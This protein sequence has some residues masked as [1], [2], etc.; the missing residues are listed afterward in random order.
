[1][2]GVGDAYPS[3][4]NDDPLDDARDDSLGVSN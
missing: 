3:G 1:M 4:T 2:G